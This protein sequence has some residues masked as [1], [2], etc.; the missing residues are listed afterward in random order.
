MLEYVNGRIADGGQM[1]DSSEA[2][3]MI[4]DGQHKG[5]TLVVN[6]AKHNCGAYGESMLCSCGAHWNNAMNGCWQAGHQRREE[7]DRR[8]AFAPDNLLAAAYALAANVEEE[9][10]E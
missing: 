9:L 6:T 8:L 7:G 3:F 4:L 1:D 5:H 2:T 10:A